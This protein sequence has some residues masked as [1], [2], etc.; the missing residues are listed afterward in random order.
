MWVAVNPLTFGLNLALLVSKNRIMVTNI[1]DF[2][3][4]KNWFIA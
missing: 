4:G 2:M 3:T 1:Y